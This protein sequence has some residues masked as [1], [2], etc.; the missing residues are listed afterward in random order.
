M[1]KLFPREPAH[2]AFCHPRLHK[3]KLT[4]IR[5]SD[6]APQ[7]IRRL[8]APTPRLEACASV[9]R[10]PSSTG[11]SRT[12][13]CASWYRYHLTRKPISG[14]AIRCRLFTMN[15]QPYSAAWR[16]FSTSA[17]AV[18][19]T[20]AMPAK[21]AQLKE[22]REACRRDLRRIGTRCI[23]SQMKRSPPGEWSTSCGPKSRAFN[24]LSAD[25]SRSRPSGLRPDSL[26]VRLWQA[27]L[28]KPHKQTRESIMMRKFILST[29][30]VASQKHQFFRLSK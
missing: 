10:R 1:G 28:P 6:H 7:S 14:A 9:P 22:E 4:K 13:A 3:R 24:R 23:A 21:I 29:A 20:N 2:S 18:E 11:A 30:S 8:R 5:L 15:N 27:G 17:R 19:L 16:S 26:F 12:A 25:T